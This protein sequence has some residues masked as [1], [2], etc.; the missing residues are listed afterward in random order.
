MNILVPPVPLPVPRKRSRRA[1]RRAR[2]LHA[3]RRAGAY[4]MDLQDAYAD[5]A[6]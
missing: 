4:L 1:R 6:R 2:V 5:T 3:R